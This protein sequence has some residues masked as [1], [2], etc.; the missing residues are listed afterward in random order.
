MKRAT[1]IYL[2]VNAVG[3]VLFLWLVFRIEQFARMEQRD[4]RD[5]GDSLNFLMTAVPVFLAC[6]VYTLAW[7]VKALFDY[8]RKRGAQGLKALATVT[9]AWT[10]MIVSLRILL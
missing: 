3:L 9:C 1:I 6:A 8:T 4:Y 10:V 7:G 5:F 2:V